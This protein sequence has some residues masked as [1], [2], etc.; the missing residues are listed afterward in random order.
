VYK[1]FGRVTISDGQ[2]KFRFQ[3]PSQSERA[4]SLESRMA[5]VLKP[6]A[7][8]RDA[9]EVV[10]NRS[11]WCSFVLEDPRGE[12]RVCDDL[13]PPPMSVPCLLGR[14]ALERHRPA[15]SN[16]DAPPPILTKTASGS[17]EP[18]TFTLCWDGCKYEVSRSGWRVIERRGAFEVFN[19]A[20]TNRAL[21][22]SSS[23]SSSSLSRNSSGGGSK[24]TSWAFFS[25][26]FTPDEPARK[27]YEEHTK[28]QHT[29][30]EE[31]L[32]VVC[33]HSCDAVMIAAISTFQNHYILGVPFLL[34]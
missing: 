19:I 20:S 2:W 30:E 12:G 1:R 24:S 32:P 26:L 16:P 18:L 8:S 7:T 31:V 10:A 3:E 29:G 21:S 4:T 34:L 9:N 33:L 23:S 27:A 6:I 17:T 11:D 28:R 5:W 13:K 22:S 25:S 15:G 14:N